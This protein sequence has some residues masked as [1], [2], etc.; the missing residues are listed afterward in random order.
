MW[1]IQAPENE[2][3]NTLNHTPNHTIQQSSQT[4]HVDFAGNDD[5]NQP[6]A[7]FFKQFVR[8]WL[9]R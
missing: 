1:D 4:A 2:I 6:G 3:N 5:G 7:A 8:V 9:R